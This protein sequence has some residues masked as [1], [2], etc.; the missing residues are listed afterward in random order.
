[1]TPMKG[2]R[3]F[4]HSF[5]YAF[6]GIRAAVRSEQNMRFHLMAGFYVF[7]FS[8]FY[9]FSKLEYALLIVLVSGVIALELMNSSIE[10][11]VDK[12]TPGK[13]YIV[14]AVKDMAA[15]G[16]LIFSVGAAVCGLL[17]FWD[18]PTFFRIYRYF[19]DNLLALAAL[20]GSLICAGMFVFRQ[21]D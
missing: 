18:I 20:V 17:L 1:M 10:R 4:F 8:A 14:G 19:T 21:E 16:V 2:L 3:K 9:D 5:Q 12:P 15:G 13:F 11:A 7:L 6:N